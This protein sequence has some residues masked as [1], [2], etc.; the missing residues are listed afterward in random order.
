[1]PKDGLM[2]HTHTKVTFGV[3]FSCPT[4]TDQVDVITKLLL[5][6]WWHFFFQILK[7]LP[8]CSCIHLL[9]VLV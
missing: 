8:I 1:M 2:L 3:I 4:L 9:K 6:K 5:Q 7:A